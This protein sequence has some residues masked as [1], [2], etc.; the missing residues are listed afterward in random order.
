MGYQYALHQYKKK[1][2]EE[3]D[4]FMRSRDDNSTS[5]GGHWDEYSDASEYSMER[6]RD[7]KHNRRTTAQTR[8]ESYA[9]SLSAQQ[10]KKEENFVQETPEAA[11]IAAQTYLLTTQPEPGDPRKHKHQAAIRSLGL[12]EH[13]L[14]GKLLEEKATHHK[15]RRKEEFKRKPS[16]NESSES[17]G[18]ERRQK[19]AG[20]RKKHNSTSTSEQLVLCVER[21]KLRRR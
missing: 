13:K 6:R 10:S 15:E 3:K 17:S 5:S 20:G 2:R 12:I 9:K 8:E 7:P 19:I 1:L 14:M 16:R 4:M 18:D 11:L 21:G